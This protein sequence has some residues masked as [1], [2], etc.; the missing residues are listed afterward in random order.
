MTRFLNPKSKSN[1]SN[2]KVVDFTLKEELATTSEDYFPL[3]FM[4]EIAMTKG[5]DGDMYYCK[6]CGLVKAKEDAA[7]TAT[8]QSLDK[9]REQTGPKI[10]KKNFDVAFKNITYAQQTSPTSRYKRPID[11]LLDREEEL[12]EQRLKDGGAIIGDSYER[13]Y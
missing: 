13:K 12:E 3:C 5:R 8:K 11:E 1:Y 4:C 6:G 9:R 10:A 7:D 2:Y